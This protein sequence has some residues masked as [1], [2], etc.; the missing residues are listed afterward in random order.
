[1]LCEVRLLNTN[2]S[3]FQLSYC[4]FLTIFLSVG[5]MVEFT[6]TVA[7]EPIEYRG[8]EQSTLALSRGNKG[9][10]AMGNLNREFETGLPDGEYCDIIS[11]CQQKIQVMRRVVRMGGGP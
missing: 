8:A 3:G 11:E 1:M 10:F 6:N 2:I 7:G 9:F 4:D 5:Q